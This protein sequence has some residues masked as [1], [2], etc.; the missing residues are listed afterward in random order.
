MSGATGGRVEGNF[1]EL[2]GELERF[3]AETAERLALLKPTDTIK[4]IFLKGYLAAYRAEGGEALYERCVALLGER[5]IVDL[6]NYPYA[7]VMKIGVLG[8]EVL[9][10]RMGGVRPYLRA[11]GRLAV[12]GYLGSTLG[13]AFMALVHPTPKAMLGMLPTAIKTSF[14]FGERWVTF[15]GDA[16][17]FQCRKDFSPSEANAGAIEAVLRATRVSKVEVSVEQHAMLDYDLKARWSA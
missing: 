2:A 12:E 11:M 14:S 16:C 3:R 4:G 6:F 8:A 9:G 13:K 10:A 1:E 7:G 17:V 15:D 5:R